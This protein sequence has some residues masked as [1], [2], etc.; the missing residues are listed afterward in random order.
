LIINKG[1][2]VANG[3]P[4]SLR[5]HA[6]GKSIIMVDIEGGTREAVRDALLA[7]PGVTGL[8]QSADHK[9]LE[10]ECFDG[11]QTA[12]AIYKMC[13]SKEWMLLQMSPVEVKLEDIFRNVTMN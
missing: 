3:T 12:R 1:Q 9:L 2:I 13:V 6:S 7:L 11:N 8:G 10:V 5:S 4:E